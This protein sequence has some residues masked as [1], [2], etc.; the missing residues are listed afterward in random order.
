MKKSVKGALA[1]AAGLVGLFV[2]G[3]VTAQATAL[4]GTAKSAYLRNTTGYVRLKKTMYVGIY[5]KSGKKVKPLLKKKGSLLAIGGIGGAQA[6]KDKAGNIVIR[7]AFTSGAVHYQRLKKLSYNGKISIPFTKAH[8]KTATLK[9]PVRTLLFR[10][11][12]GFETNEMGLITPA[13]FY[14][15][16]DN[17]LQSYSATAMAKF[18]PSGSEGRLAAYE[19]WK[20]TSAVKV[21]KVT[22]KGRTTTIDYRQPVAGMPN[23]KVAKHHYRLTI[24]DL[25]QKH[26]QSFFPVDDTYDSQ[27]T[28]NDY[29]VNGKRYYVGSM[30]N[31]L[32]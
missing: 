18:S 15:T 27:G 1:I 17:Y 10:K 6:D 4:P 29:T 23:K 12:T 13:A 16:L 26:S 28:W 7:A 24:K 21:S 8:F 32:D 5:Q 30:E 3:G 9:A 2:G 25:N 22:V 20:P 19:V 11:G 14:L 31:G